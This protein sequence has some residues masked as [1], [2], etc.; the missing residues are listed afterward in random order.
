[1]LY[2]SGSCSDDNDSNGDS[3]N[4]AF[5]PNIPVQ[6]SGINPTTGDSGSD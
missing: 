6:V 3:D 5:D 1:M 4:A 2:S